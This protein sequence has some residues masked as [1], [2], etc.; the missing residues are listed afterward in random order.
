MIC[1]TSPHGAAKFSTRPAPDWGREVQHFCDK[2]QKTPGHGRG[3][4]DSVA[5]ACGTELEIPLQFLG[6]HFAVHA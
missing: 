6:I 1:S 3:E 2:G 5:R 4:A